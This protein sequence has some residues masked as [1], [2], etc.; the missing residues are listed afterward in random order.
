MNL[1]YARLIVI[2]SAVIVVS[3][4]RQNERSEP[5]GD[6]VARQA[7]I[8]SEST[9]STDKDDEWPGLMVKECKGIWEQWVDFRHKTADLLGVQVDVLLAARHNNVAAAQKKA[10]DSMPFIKAA[11]KSA[12][13]LRQAFQE[14]NLPKDLPEG[15]RNAFVDYTHIYARFADVKG[16]STRVVAL[17][18]AAKSGDLRPLMA[19]I[20]AD[21]KLAGNVE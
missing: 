3:C 12:R 16:L 4:G 9:H 14:R 10:R 11:D 1:H 18:A 5:T 7:A 2:S 13:V 21:K 15:V 8:Q 19:M 17:S 6:S 20:E